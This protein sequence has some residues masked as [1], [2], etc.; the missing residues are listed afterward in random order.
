MAQEPRTVAA[1]QAGLYRVSH[2][3]QG[4]FEP[5]DWDYADPEDGTF[6][7]RFDDPDALMLPRERRFRVVYCATERIGAFGETLARFRAPLSTLAGLEEIDDEEPVEES[8]AGAI[9]PQDSERILVGADWRSQRM[10]S[11]TILEP[12]LRF[13]DLTAPKTIH[14]LRRALAATAVRLGLY[15]VDE[16]TLMGSDREFTRRVARYLYELT[17]EAGRPRYAGIRYCSRLCLEWECWA[18]YAD[19]IKHLA[20]M[21]GLA[22]TIYPNDPDL[23][24]IAHLWGLTIEGLP[25]SNQFYRP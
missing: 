21:P 9:D 6:G 15:D 19:R 20:G 2:R 5:P 13:V 14:A 17:D 23:T 22:E 12:S 8:L 7:N 16:A 10:V 25:G 11:H 3:G 24:A 1:P 18:L 4:S